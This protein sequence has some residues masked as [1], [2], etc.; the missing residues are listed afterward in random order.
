MR[1]NNSDSIRS[2]DELKPK[3]MILREL[4]DL[5]DSLIYQQDIDKSEID[6]GFL[7]ASPIFIEGLDR[8]K[9]SLVPLKFQD[10]KKA[11]VEAIKQSD[12]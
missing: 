12:Q 11:I 3:R 5:K 4:Q 9:M 10:E 8:G 6:I 7:H 1:R 2:K